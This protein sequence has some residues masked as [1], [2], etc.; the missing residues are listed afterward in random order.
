MVLLSVFIIPRWEQ[1][2][3]S[4]K[5]IFIFNHAVIYEMPVAF[6]AIVFEQDALCIYNITYSYPYF[7]ISAFETVR[8]ASLPEPIEVV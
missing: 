5:I 1:K 7:V 8:L 6:A 3:K 2:V 4:F